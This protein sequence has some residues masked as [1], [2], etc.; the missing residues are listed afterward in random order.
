MLGTAELSL[1]SGDKGKEWLV[2]RLVIYGVR[3][4]ALFVQTVSGNRTP[5][6]P[7]STDLSMQQ[8]AEWDALMK[9]HGL[10]ISDMEKA[11]SAIPIGR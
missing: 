10:K 5:T 3:E 7:M 8:K 2:T 4:K 9:K 1:V 6:P 11:K